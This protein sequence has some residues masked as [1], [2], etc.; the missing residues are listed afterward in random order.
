MSIRS[1]HGGRVLHGVRA[2]VRRTVV[3]LSAVRPQG[4]ACA[5]DGLSQVGRQVPV[6]HDRQLPSPHR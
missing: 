1:V 2:R 5:R 6:P 4:T 3:R